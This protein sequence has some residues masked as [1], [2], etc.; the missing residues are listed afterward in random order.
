ME[1]KY[2]QRIEEK[3]Q[4]KVLIETYWNVNAS[5][6]IKKNVVVGVLIETYWNVNFKRLYMRPHSVPVL[7][8]TYWN[9][10]DVKSLKAQS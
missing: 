4:Y 9:V 5:V 8:E 3:K 10:N 6:V 2:I 1:C 7:I